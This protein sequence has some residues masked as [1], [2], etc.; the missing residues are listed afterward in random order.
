MIVIE[1]YTLEDR[2][3]NHSN[4]KMENEH[5]W[6]STSEPALAIVVNSPETTS[7]EILPQCSVSTTRMYSYEHNFDPNVHKGCIKKCF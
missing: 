5:K 6:A 3:D 2:G 7:D 1:S 4:T